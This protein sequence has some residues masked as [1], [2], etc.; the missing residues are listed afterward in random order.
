MAL[1]DLSIDGCPSEAVPFKYNSEKSVFEPAQPGEPGIEG[2]MVIE[3]KFTIPQ[4]KE[5]IK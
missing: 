2:D 3:T 4:I 5:V 1:V